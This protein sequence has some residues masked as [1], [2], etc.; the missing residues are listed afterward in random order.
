MAEIITEMS[1]DLET[2]SEANLKKT[3]V[4]RYAADQSIEILLAGVSVNGGPVHC[5]GLASGEILPDEIIRALTDGHVIKLAFNASF[6]SLTLH[7]D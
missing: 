3:G 6:K 5:Y 2:Y 1:W 4:Y 7:M